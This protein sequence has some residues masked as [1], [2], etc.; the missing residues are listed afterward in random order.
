MATQNVTRE[1]LLNQ[2]KCIKYATAILDYTAPADAV[3]VSTSAD[4]YELFEMP[5]D[6]VLIVEANLFVETA[7][8]AVTSAVADIGFDGGD[9]LLDGVNLKSAANTDL[10]GGTN[11]VV[12]QLI[13][14]GGTV[15]FLPTYTGT[16]TAGRFHLRIGY[17][18]IE[19]KTGELT[20]F[21]ST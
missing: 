16:T 7:S 18:E 17:I 6:A 13:T 19:K 1:G 10:S 5:G 2:K 12:P 11:A 14:S 8:D 20:N 21:S 15:T 9:T 3:D 4:V